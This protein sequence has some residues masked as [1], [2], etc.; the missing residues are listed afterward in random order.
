MSKPAADLRRDDIAVCVSSAVGIALSVGSWSATRGAN[1]FG[2]ALITPFVPVVMTVAALVC[3]AA[4]RNRRPSRRLLFA[5]ATVF[6]AIQLLATLLAPFSSNAERA[7]LEIVA[8][9]SEGLSS[10]LLVFLYLASLTHLPSRRIALTIAG[11]YLLVHLYD[12][13]FLGASEGI[14][15]LQRQ[16]GLAA[17]VALAGFLVYHDQ[18]RRRRA[19]TEPTAGNEG[20]ARPG[21]P[22][23]APAATLGN[24]G[25]GVV[26]NT[27]GNTVGDVAGDVADYALLACFVSALLLIQ[28]VYSQVTGL[29]SVDNTQEFNLFT[30]LFA[31]GVRIAVLAYFLL[32]GGDLSL[33]RIAAFACAVFLVGIPAVYLSWGSDW[34][35]IGSHIVNSAR[36]ALLPLVSIAGVQTARR[37]PERTEPLVFG[38]IAAANCCYVSRLATGAILGAATDVATVIPA[39]SLFS[40]WAVACLV[41]AYILARQHLWA[42]VTGDPQGGSASGPAGE[43]GQ[44]CVLSAIADPSIQ[45]EVLFYQRLNGLC[46]KAQLTEREKDI[47]REV[48]HGYSIDR[49]SVRLSLSPSTVKTYLR[50]AYTRFGVSSRQEVLDLLDSGTGSTASHGEAVPL[51]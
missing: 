8:T 7:I 11:G 17:M 10:T 29:G 24:H 37:F 27:A 33:P 36:Y 32:K 22:T 34:Y 23:R 41:P 9:A 51:A 40:M 45:S 48:M 3:A 15:P 2:S 1:V 12:G 49:I 43:S 35:L 14:R 50:R 21:T 44:A 38:A 31:A 18:K 28:G 6:G 20:A 42:R 47:V 46:D 26:G 30:E 19:Q 25:G 16:L 13:L 5:A 39:V 4:F